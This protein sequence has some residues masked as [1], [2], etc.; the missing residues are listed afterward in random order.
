[1]LF[2]RERTASS[3]LQLLGS[4]GLAVVVLTHFAEVF[5]LLSWMRWSLEESPGHYLDL[6]GASLAVTLFPTGYLIYAL[7]K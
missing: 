1:V 5:D 7:R 4:G 2:F 6:G 3:F